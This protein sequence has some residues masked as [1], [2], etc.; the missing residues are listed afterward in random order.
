[1]SE[2]SRKPHLCDRFRACPA[3]FWRFTSPCYKDPALESAYASS[4]ADRI[5]ASGAWSSAFATGILACHALPMLEV[6]NA[7]QASEMIISLSLLQTVLPCA[8]FC[9]TLY[10][11][12]RAWVKFKIV[13][14][15]VLAAMS[16]L[17]L[18][19]GMVLLS[20]LRF[21]AVR[22]DLQFSAECTG[23]KCESCSWMETLIS[24]VLSFLI[25]LWMPL[26]SRTVALLLLS[27]LTIVYLSDGLGKA[28]ASMSLASLLLY[29]GARRAEHLSRL[30]F[31][32]LHEQKELTTLLQEKEG[33]AKSNMALA[34]SL[35]SLAGRRCDLVVI[36]DANLAVW[37]PTPLQDM[38]FKQDMQQVLLTDVLPVSEQE[39]FL[40]LVRRVSE[41]KSAEAL[42]ITLPQGRAK[43]ILEYAG[44]EEDRFVMSILLDE[45]ADQVFNV[46]DTLIQTIAGWK[47]G[48]N[49]MMQRE[50]SNGKAAS[51]AGSLDESLCYSASEPGKSSKK[52]SAII[53]FMSETASGITRLKP[54]MVDKEVQVVDS[55]LEE[56]GAKKIHETPSTGRPPPLPLNQ[57]RPCSSSASSGSFRSPPV[58]A[59]SRSKGSSRGVS[60]LKRSANP[61]TPEGD[62]ELL[63][64]LPMMKLTAPFYDST[65]RPCIDTSMLWLLQHW[66]FSYATVDC[67][68][69]HAAMQI[70]VRLLK[71]HKKDACNPL[72]S[73][74][75][76]WQCELCTGMNHEQSVICDLCGSSRPHRPEQLEPLL[77]SRSLDSSDG[78]HLFLNQPYQQDDAFHG[79]ASV[80]NDHLDKDHLCQ[81]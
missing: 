80:P 74:F 55:E 25:V 22:Q 45:N 31:K 40:S 50:R 35:Q 65:S 28:L 79:G 71:S 38:F 3:S 36:L 78:S 15:E 32:S 53:D 58:R 76:G 8:M 21:A 75:T 16:G 6:T 37:R 13:P 72:W 44:C 70:A 10:F 51:Q 26:R 11:G 68:P 7:M 39:M 2:L 46:D 5:A 56:E 19:G 63:P 73:P 52:S 67:C 4:Q 18:I 64:N 12:V 59:R 62:P 69:R 42:A 29:G 49:D 23:C 77:G 60:S 81:L 43:V 41:H 14:D 48:E 33:Q 30:G 20:P 47:F 1:M 54:P 17:L 61:N 66:N 27:S 34:R 24:Q 9:F 57:V